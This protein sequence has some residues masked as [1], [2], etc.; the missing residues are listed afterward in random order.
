[1]IAR[2][3][4]SACTLTVLCLWPRTS[5][6]AI[7]LHHTNPRALF[8]RKGILSDLTSQADLPGAPRQIGDDQIAQIAEA[9]T[10]TPETL[11]A[12]ATHRNRRSMALASGLSAT[13][14]HRI[15][16]AFGP[17]PHRVQT[18]KLSNDPWF[19]DK[20]RDI[21]GLYLDPPQRAL[22]LCIDEKSQI[23]ALD[24]TQPVLPLRPG[25][26]E[27]RA[28]GYKHYR[29]TTLFATLDLVAGSVIGTCMKRRRARPAP[30]WRWWSG[31]CPPISTST[32]L[33]ATLPATRPS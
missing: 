7:G 33:W 8:L 10:R 11:P 1:M 28:H 2:H 32:S 23:Q 5:T 20:V 18:F 13:T 9:V 4:S 17:Q 27:R 19:V 12:D 6:E 3:W 16:S 14:V 26:A 25:Q 30:S 15:W 21:I 31:P 29:T 22:V 24:R